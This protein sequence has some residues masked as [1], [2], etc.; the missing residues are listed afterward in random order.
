MRTLLLLGLSAL[1]LATSRIPHPRWLE[2]IV[3][4]TQISDSEFGEGRQYQFVYNG[5]LLNGLPQS[6]KQHS[7]TRLQAVCTVAFKSQTRC[8]LK[9][10]HIRMGKLNGHVHEPREMLPFGHFEEVPI[11]QQLKEQLHASVKFTYQNGMISDIVF[12]GI[13]QPWSANIKRGVL[14]MLQVNLS[15]RGRTD[16]T[17]DALLRN[18]V[19]EPE[20][21][22]NAYFTAVEKTLEGECECDYTVNSQPPRRFS[23]K[24]PVLNVTKS[25]NFEKCRIRPEIKYNYRF[26]SPCPTCEK[27]YTSEEKMIR[28]STVT[29]YQIK[30]TT[31]KF[32]IEQSVCDSQYVHVPLGEEAN[33]MTTYVKQELKL[34]KS[35]PIEN[36]GQLEPSNE[37]PSDS[38]MIY[39]RDW[40]VLKEQFF[41]E[42][43]ESFHQET[44]FPGIKNK[45]QFVE[46]ILRR[47][48]RH[49]SESVEEEAPRQFV[50]LVTVLRTCKKNELSE[51]HETF[52]KSTPSSFTPEDHKKIKDLLVDAMAVA[53]TKDCVTHLINTIKRREIHPVKASLTIKNLINIRVPSQ[54]IIEQLM[55]LSENEVCQ[56][57]PTLKQSVELTTGSL[58][59]ALCGEHEDKLAI[60]QNKEQKEKQC[61]RSLKE[62]YVEKLFGKLRSASTPSEQMLVLKTISNC[63]I[64]LSIFELEK[65]IKDRSMPLSSRQ[66]AMMA[67][68]LLRRTMPRKIQKVLMPIF[69]NERKE[70]AMLRLLASYQIMQ[71][72]PERSLLDQITRQ[73]MRERNGQIAALLVS[74]LQSFA[75]STN[76]CEKRV[77]DDLKL[78]LRRAS[79]G[80]LSPL[81]PY[82]A[83]MHR[84]YSPKYDKGVSFD[85]FMA[86]VN[87]T[88]LPSHMAFAVNINSMGQWL[89]NVF[90]VSVVQQNAGQWLLEKLYGQSGPIERNLE[91]ILRRSPRSLKSVSPQNEL[92]KIFEKLE[93]VERQSGRMGPMVLPTVTIKNQVVGFLP[94]MPQT[95]PES[96]RE[97]I[98]E[99]RINIQSMERVM[100]EGVPMDMYQAFMLF[101]QSRKIP[102]SV[103]LPIRFSTKLPV[104]MRLSGQVKAQIEP[105]DSIQKAKLTVDIKPS[106]AAKWTVKMES[107]SP[108]VNSGLKLNGQMKAFLPINCELKVDT[109]KNPTETEL[110][111]KPHPRKYEMLTLE[112]RPVCYTYD[113]PKFLETWQEPQMRTI[114]GEEW[115]RVNTFDT[116]VGEQALGIKFRLQG[117]WHKSPRKSVS[118]TPICPFSGPNKL[119]LTVE[120]GQ[121]MPKEV[122]V[123]LT[124]KLFQKS[125]KPLQPEFGNF[126]D[127]EDKSFFRSSS[128]EESSEESFEEF[129]TRE[130]IN[131]QVAIKIFTQGSS[132]KR[133]CLI[134]TTCKCS[135][136]QRHCRCELDIK[137]SP[138]PGVES[139][140]WKLNSYVETFYP[141]TP[142]HLSELSED[143]QFLCNIKSTWGQNKEKKVEIKV[144]GARSQKQI[145][146]LRRE[147]EQYNSECSSPICQYE[148][149]KRAAVLTD[150][151]IDVDYELGKKEM[152]ITNALY[153]MLKYKYY[154]LTSVDQVN[155][156]NPEN[157]VR[158]RITIDPK[159]R[160]YVNVTIK[161]PK[162]RCQF[163]DIPLP[164]KVQPVNL[165]TRS[166]RVRSP[167]EWMQS[168]IEPQM[169]QCKVRT[170]TVQTF[171][172]VRIRVPFSKECYSILAKDCSRPQNP[173]F[174]VLTKKDSPNNSKKQVKIITQQHIIKLRSK[175]DH[176]IIC[177]INGEEKPIERIDEV[178]EHG[179]VVV[180]VSREGPYVK[181]SLPEAGVKVFYDGYATNIKMSQIYRNIQCGLCGHYDGDRQN[182]L[183]TSKYELVEDLTKFHRSY[184]LQDQ[185]TLEEELINNPEE[186]LYQPEQEYNPDWR[187]SKS[188]SCPHITSMSEIFNCVEEC[189][190][191][192]ACNGEKKCCY[193]GCGHVCVE[194]REKPE[195]RQ[196][197]REPVRRT[198][199]IEHSHE[200]CFSK[201]PV[202]VCP[203]NTYPNEYKEEKKVVY[204]C[205]PRT[206]P[207][208]EVLER[209][210]RRNQVVSQVSKLASSF[211][212]PELI[213]EKCRKL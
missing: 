104:I 98:D 197:N 125:D 192:E 55:K 150:Y 176:E 133:N 94:I 75:N 2:E 99:E 152:N 26:S 185:C 23:P 110:K 203:R 107:W 207:Q 179:H 45:I 51:I 30:G 210:A 12:D 84:F 200:I 153:R 178:R 19:Q 120:P 124:G 41:Q 194:P 56:R 172:G 86:S 117:S 3:P 170:Q 121:E 154:W 208:A 67:L 4:E 163:K 131:S 80:P 49:I 21:K 87:S 115:N 151:K 188:G 36:L 52:F 62:K 88:Y 40:D 211:T 123:R 145:E 175:P 89:K 17:E 79:L 118:G 39:T 111:C 205:L 68:R 164:M 44:P 155:V 15:Q 141:E 122:I 35:G 50:R 204:C 82:Y 64:D 72:L 34:V 20:N 126:Y 16:R 212:E 201:E 148:T 10:T 189:N 193:N 92:K 106:I 135:E 114:Y 144:Q 91:D 25:I 174:A 85:M 190:K 165:R 101:D 61:P 60:Q 46:Q 78:S 202:P 59:H 139:G 57:S 136:R 69:M 166:Q 43:D 196:Q 47:L 119:Q 6:S 149:L 156:N 93:I 108:I 129:K 70:P 37:Q 158:A 7:A 137:R 74:Q 142:F 13:E 168:W 209:E 24:E 112:T 177:E 83:G 54:E 8:L 48:V 27:R 198:K 116:K 173:R 33:V 171:D 140:E 38:Q 65:I 187:T 130:P 58:I 147:Q 191:D 159:N 105:T 160:Q 180:R 5:Q 28:S 100:R 63:G 186:Y 213:P 128:S 161:T 143:K 96:L 42:G 199:V 71:T 134:E 66:E 11:E 138:I 206:D 14:N 1:A 90:R 167:S 103:G 22:N 18:D 53:G 81:A 127:E 195:R 162:E 113:W 76:P 169:A 29:K 32:L 77:A 9:C 102:T 184:L 182:E 109:N 95:I 181:V 132:I 183:R 73:L 31:E 157:Q 146:Q 97:L